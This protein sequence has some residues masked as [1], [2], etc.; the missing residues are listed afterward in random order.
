MNFLKIVW[1]DFMNICRTP[2]LVIVNT[3]GQLIIW[4]GFGMV[5]SSHFGGGIVN[6]YDYYGIATMI[7]SSIMISMTVTNT[8]MEEKVKRGNLRIAYA[9]VSKT[10]IYLS[11]LLSTYIFGVIA[12]TLL[13]LLEQ[14]VFQS[15]FG[16]A[17]IGYIMILIHMLTLFGCC[18]GTLVVVMFKSEERA[19]AVMPIISILFIFFGGVFSPVGHF[20]E[21]MQ[22]IAQI[23]PAKWVTQAAFQIIYDNNFSLFLPVIAFLLLFSIVFTVIS[24]FIFKPEEYL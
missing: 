24:Q 18:I 3:I 13:C 14:M 8:F 23:S 12:F 20:G 15:N 1:F 7:L 22:A 10:E 16:G 19:N 2:M 4:A 9:P 5:T 17:N 6:S 21:V 11:K